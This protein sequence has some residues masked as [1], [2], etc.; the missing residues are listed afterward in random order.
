[1]RCY[2]NNKYWLDVEEYNA[3]QNITSFNKM[4]VWFSI[5]ETKDNLFYIFDLEENKRISL[6]SAL[7]Y[8]NEGLLE[9]DFRMLSKLQQK[10]LNNMFRKYNLEECE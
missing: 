8:I 9:E 3:L 5:R 10:A 6:C 2:K 7:S 1:M 4:D